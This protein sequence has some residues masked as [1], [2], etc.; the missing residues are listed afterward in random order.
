[1]T[2]E[3]FCA[4]PTAVLLNDLIFHDYFMIRDPRGMAAYK[5]LSNVLKAIKKAF[6][7]IVDDYVNYFRAR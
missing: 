1:M 7:I 4:P 2:Y 6:L 5:R 3:Q